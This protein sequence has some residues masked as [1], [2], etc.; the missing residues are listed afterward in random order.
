MILSPLVNTFIKEYSVP[1][2]ASILTTSIVLYKHILNA[3][4]PFINAAHTGAALQYMRSLE[5]EADKKSA[6]VTKNPGALVQALTKC[7]QHATG[8]DT[9]TPYWKQMLIALFTT[10]PALA[11]RVAALEQIAASFD[12]LPSTLK[13][14]DGQAG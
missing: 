3:T 12:K 2:A 11:D 14:F 4:T 13:S 1:L 6:M 5:Y 7:H 8:S 9:P 10:H